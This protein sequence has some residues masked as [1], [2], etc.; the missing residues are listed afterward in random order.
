M[1][2]QASLLVLLVVTNLSMNAF[3]SE[4]A[5]DSV[6]EKTL[7]EDVWTE[8]IS[9][10]EKK[11]ETTTKN[12]LSHARCTMGYTILHHAAVMANI[13]MLELI[14]KNWVRHGL[15]L[16]ELA[17]RR[18]STPSHSA[19]QLLN[20]NTPEVLKTLKNAGA[21]ADIQRGI[22]KKSPLQLVEEKIEAKQKLISTEENEDNLVKLKSELEILEQSKIVL[23]ST[24]K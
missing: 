2:K 24:Q 1:L 6:S 23:T 9:D 10:L 21:T 4:S 13:P 16:D 7:M 12:D 18:G 22:D 19:L 3:A 5:T 8:D 11:F 17:G 20:K 15:N 14:V